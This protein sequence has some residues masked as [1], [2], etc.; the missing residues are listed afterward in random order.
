MVR[1]GARGALIPRL[2]FRDGNVIISLNNNILIPFLLRFYIETSHRV[3]SY[4]SVGKIKKSN[5]RDKY[6][7]R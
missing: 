3:R 1:N 6:I 2:Q 4:G 7:S 5:R